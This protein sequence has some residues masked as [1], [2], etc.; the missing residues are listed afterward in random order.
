MNKT[1]W[2]KHRAKMF[3]NITDWTSEQEELKNKPI[4]QMS[5]FDFYW[6]SKDCFKLLHYG[7]PSF[8]IGFG[9]ILGSIIYFRWGF[10]PFIILPG[11]MAVIG[12]KQLIERIK[13]REY[14]KDITMY[15]LNLKDDFK[16]E[17]E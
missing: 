8:T 3:P 15:D 7:I 4:K 1:Y 6:F 14:T 2:L 5:Y 9:L 17:T 12:L 11:M 16:E 13:N 10:S